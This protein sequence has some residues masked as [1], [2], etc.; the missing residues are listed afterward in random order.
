MV[1]QLLHALELAVRCIGLNLNA[2]KKGSYD[3]NSK[4]TSYVPNI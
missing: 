2:N 4:E 3:L 1:S